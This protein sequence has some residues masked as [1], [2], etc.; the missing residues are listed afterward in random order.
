MCS[1]DRPGINIMRHL[2][3]APPGVVTLALL[4]VSACGW[5]YPPSDA[6][7]AEAFLKEHPG[8]A[9]TSVTSVYPN[10]PPGRKGGDIVEKHIRFRAPSSQTEC[11]V[12]WMFTD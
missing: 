12:V 3:R 7:V 1:A 4:C 5:P 9:V 6:A 8:A 2:T 11:E 10:M